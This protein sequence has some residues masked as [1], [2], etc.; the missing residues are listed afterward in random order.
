MTKDAMGRV[1]AHF[2]PIDMNHPDIKGELAVDETLRVAL[3]CFPDTRNH[4]FLERTSSKRL[5]HQFPTFKYQFVLHRPTRDKSDSPT[6]PF[7]PTSACMSTLLTTGVTHVDPGNK[8][9]AVDQDIQ[10]SMT[11]FVDEHK[12]DS[13]EFKAATLIII[14]TS[15]RDFSYHVSRMQSQGGF[16][17]IVIIAN[18]DSNPNSAFLRC[19]GRGRAVIA[20]RRIVDIAR[21]VPPSIAAPVKV[22]E[23]TAPG[24]GSRSVTPPPAPPPPPPPSGLFKHKPSGHSKALCKFF[25]SEGRLQ[26]LQTELVGIH[27]RFTIHVALE[28]LVL[29]AAEVVS[30]DAD[31]AL[32]APAPSSEPSAAQ[33]NVAAEKMRI[34][35]QSACAEAVTVRGVSETRLAR[36]AQLLAFARVNNTRIFFPKGGERI[37]E[38]VKHLIEPDMGAVSTVGPGAGATQPVPKKNIIGFIYSSPCT[39]E[40]VRALA[41]TCDAPI[42]YKG[43]IRC[44]EID[45]GVFLGSAPL[46]NSFASSKFTADTLE[47]KLERL[48]ALKKDPRIRFFPYG[49]DPPEIEGYA[50]TGVVVVCSFKKD[51]ADAKKVKQ[52]LLSR[53][54]IFATITVSP[55]IEALV[56]SAWQSIRERLEAV[57][58]KLEVDL[59]AP[60]VFQPQK[61]RS[62]SFGRRPTKG[63]HPTARGMHRSSSFTRN[64]GAN[65][66]ASA[67]GSGGTSSAGRGGSAMNGPGGHGARGGRGGQDW[68]CTKCSNTNFGSKN[69][70]RCHRCDAPKP[71]EVEVRFTGLPESV[72]K[73]RVKLNKLLLSIE[74]LK[75]DVPA[76]VPHRALC[77]LL[78]SV[79]ASLLDSPPDADGADGAD[80]DVGSAM[81]ASHC[82]IPLWTFERTFH[83]SGR[84]EV[85]VYFLPEAK[86]EAEEARKKAAA[87]MDDLDSLTVQVVVNGKLFTDLRKTF[88]LY[89]TDVSGNAIRLTGPRSEASA[90]RDYLV[91]KVRGGAAETRLVVLA[92]RRLWALCAQLRPPAWQPVLDANPSVTITKA[93]TGLRLSG[94][95]AMVEAAEAKWREVAAGS[96]ATLVEHAVELTQAQEAY[97]QGE[98]ATILTKI[99]API[100][101]MDDAAPSMSKPSRQPSRSGQ[102]WAETLRSAALRSNEQPQLSDAARTPLSMTAAPASQLLASTLA[103]FDA[104]AWGLSLRVCLADF[105]EVGADAVVNA[106]N[107]YL[108][109]AGGIAKAIGDAGGPAFTAECNASV[110]KLP[111]RQL[112]PGSALITGS[113]NL[114]TTAGIT[115]VVHAL[116][117]ICPSAGPS[118]TDVANLKATMRE[119]LRL[120]AE[121]GTKILAVPA[122]GCM[123]YGWSAD[124]ATR[125]IVEATVDWA[126]AQSVAPSLRRVVFC[127]I[128]TATAGTFARSLR[129]RVHNGP[130]APSPHLFNRS[131]SNSQYASTSPRTEMAVFLAELGLAAHTAVMHAEGFDSIAALGTMGSDDAVE[132]RL[133]LVTRGVP[134]GDVDHILRAAAARVNDVPRMRPAPFASCSGAATGAPVQPQPSSAGLIHTEQRAPIRKPVSLWEWYRHESSSWMKYDYDQNVRLEDWYVRTG[135]DASSHAEPVRI[136]G[137]LNG[138]VANTPNKPAGMAGG[139]YEVSRKQCDGDGKTYSM[140]QENVVSKYGRA[141]RRTPLTP[142]QESLVPMYKERLEADA[143]SRKVEARL[144]QQAHA[145]QALPNPAGPVASA[146]LPTFVPDP[147]APPS[148]PVLAPAPASGPVGAS[149][150]APPASGVRPGGWPA[151]GVLLTGLKSAGLESNLAAAKS[152]LAAALTGAIKRSE[153]PISLAA[154][155]GTF[156]EKMAALRAALQRAGADA[157]EDNPA[158]QTVRVSALG[159]GG[160]S[161][162]ERELLMWVA[163]SVAAARE[164]EAENGR[165]KFPD[166][167]EGDPFD[168]SKIGMELKPV[169]SGSR[170]YQ[171][172]CR[173]FMFR[174]DGSPPAFPNAVLSVERVQN[175]M[176]YASYDK[177]K[178]IIAAKDRNNGNPNELWMKHG[179]RLSDPKAIISGEVGLDFRYSASG[180][181]GRG[182]YLAEDAAYSARGYAYKESPTAHKMLLVRVA[183]G[184]IIESQPNANLTKEPDG[185][186]SVRGVVAPDNKAVIV[187]N[188]SQCYPAYLITYKP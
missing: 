4:P 14:I 10:K 62:A 3:G 39:E 141:V 164:R 186:D 12:A 120:A 100:D 51:A 119:A 159:E 163:Q 81:A 122:L 185:Y 156:S 89:D 5:R 30:S 11:N 137:D 66:S 181:F 109:P 155:D 150:G 98:G 128:D 1:V 124:V 173:R 87:E 60:K 61:V 31:G 83:S 57:D 74:W 175:P 157:V 58:D 126:V 37:V 162:G 171:D 160:V 139:V 94:T 8:H 64:D 146:R 43:K 45:T 149:G 70:S 21:G 73:A 143:E 28:E 113:G 9:G 153:E 67:D 79:R 44:E 85:R 183:A 15:D 97:L 53:E 25:A 16:N 34:F 65:G 93:E 24:L 102:V 101:E 19:V 166:E 103:K 184:T 133:A 125:Y 174:P 152:R 104:P 127:D 82:T 46:D 180:M 169:A 59:S 147:S 96:A 18:E 130:L 168:A 41:D 33:V 145:Q 76:R 112:A 20:W 48:C 172:V 176:A 158:L 40:D 13:E 52:M 71:E 99:G 47:D 134:R 107:P 75:I 177:W 106:A 108:H 117:P 80:D 187:Y 54:R 116:A 91:E 88:T 179:T 23:E 35:S 27:P 167:W 161:R 36:D 42:Y 123:N 90:A 131:M 115:A 165:V 178:K 49:G 114:G 86:A 63:S 56:R 188:V 105:R 7:H 111:G 121:K 132:M 142:G 182:T 22:F 55:S 148:T 50:P 69:L 110:A 140:R 84:A 138:T 17:N 95:R 92:D 135:S 6:N 29:K 38:K 32:S 2:H 68:I 170:E 129:A 78:Q 77:P 72:E 136:M 154:C 118:A 26:E 151:H 144:A